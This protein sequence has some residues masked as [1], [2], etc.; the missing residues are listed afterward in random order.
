MFPLAS[1]RGFWQN[2]AKHFNPMNF[3]KQRLHLSDLKETLV[4][5]HKL[6][7]SGKPSVVPIQSE[8][9]QRDGRRRLAQNRVV[10]WKIVTFSDDGLQITE[11]DVCA[12]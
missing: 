1:A 12:V 2:S 8:N 11:L 3:S 9:V 10:S 5:G 6:S 4:A 7:V